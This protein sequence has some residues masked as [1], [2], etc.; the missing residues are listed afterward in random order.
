MFVLAGHAGPVG[1]EE[2]GQFVGAVAEI[3][4]TPGRTEPDVTLASFQG[5]RYR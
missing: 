3:G 5:V 1:V 2:S 4:R